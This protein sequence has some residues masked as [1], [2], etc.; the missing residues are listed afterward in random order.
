[1]RI[2]E[3]A[4]FFDLDGTLTKANIW[5][6]VMDYF[7]VHHERQWT[8]RAYMAYHY[9]LYIA[10]KMGIISDGTFRRPWPA[11]LGWYLR[12]YS[13]EEADRVWSWVV[14]S[15]VNKTWRNDTCQIL[16]RRREE[17]FLTVLVSGTP[18]PLLER[19]STEIDAEHAV[20][21][22]LE[23][24]GGK[25]TGRSSGPA[26]IGKQK[27][28]LTKQHFEI[29]GIEI[30]YDASY[31]YADSVSDKN[32]LEMVGHP[33]VTYPDQRLREIAIER[34]WQIFPPDTS[35]QQ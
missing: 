4:A 33:I 1:L 7:K 14:D 28:A 24:R 10:F 3:K 20:G 29:L 16:R 23:I 27:V 17:G 32:L 21:T 5:S 26:C 9:P 12:G 13:T 15:L 19:I 11:H 22:G 30:N 31:A 2:T 8:H 6:G 35:P 25:Y 34:N 18:L